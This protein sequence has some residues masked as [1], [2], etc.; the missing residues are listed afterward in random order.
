MVNNL[1]QSVELDLSELAILTVQSESQR[2]LLNHQ[3]VSVS[4]G[5]SFSYAL[6]SVQTQLVVA[7][8]KLQGIGEDVY[9]SEVAVV[10]DR[11]SGGTVG[12]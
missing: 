4:H 8:K 6:S 11:N 7:V 1:G 9:E 12:A 10:V 2:H 3:I 5:E